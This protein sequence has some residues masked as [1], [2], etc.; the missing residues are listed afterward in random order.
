MADRINTDWKSEDDYWRT[1]YRTRPYAGSADYTAL[2][3]GYRYGYDAATKYEGRDWAEVEHDLERD[4]TTYAHRGESTWEHI[5]HA[6]RDSW[7]R[8]MGRRH[9]GAR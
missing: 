7:D 4:W 6:V 2:Q 3:P 1:N 9:V 8:M 5:K